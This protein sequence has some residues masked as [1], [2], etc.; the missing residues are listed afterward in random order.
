[1]DREVV[2]ETSLHFRLPR[3]VVEMNG[4]TTYTHLDLETKEIVDMAMSLASKMGD[5][6]LGLNTG[7]QGKLRKF[8]VGSVGLVDPETGKALQGQFHPKV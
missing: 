7:R 8:A 4:R 1:M 2:A 3:E 5:K 6:L